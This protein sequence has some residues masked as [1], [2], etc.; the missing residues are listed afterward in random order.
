MSQATA[1]LHGVLAVIREGNT[2]DP[3]AMNAIDEVV[4]AES[5]QL[6]RPE[7]VSLL[8]LVNEVQTALVDEK[9]A[10]Q[11]ELNKLSGERRAIRGYASIRSHRHS[12]R[13]NR[14]IG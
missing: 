13:I 9:Q 1:M 7:L 14:K 8:D 11:S 5:E 6:S 3:D 12:Q 4:R 2:P 10:I